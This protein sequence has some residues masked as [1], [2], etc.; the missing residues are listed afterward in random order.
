MICLAGKDQDC[1]EHSSTILVSGS[2]DCT[3]KVW[4][5]RPS[6]SGFQLLETLSFVPGFVLGVDLYTLHGHVILACGGSAETVEIYVAQ[7]GKVIVC[8]VCAL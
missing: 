6:C 4:E 5:R 7:E 1:L 8:L 2:S 3:L